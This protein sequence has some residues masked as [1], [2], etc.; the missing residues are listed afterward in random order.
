MRQTLDEIRRK[1]L[2]ALRRELGPAGMVRFL[3]QFDR[4]SGD[5]ARERRDWVDRTSLADIRAAAGP[6]RRRK[7]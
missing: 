1:G 7:K 6:K 3:Q 5:Y 2:E 4:G